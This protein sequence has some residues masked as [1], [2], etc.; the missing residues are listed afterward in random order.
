[1]Q[2]V[3]SIRLLALDFDGVI[4]DS[5]LECAVAA[6]NGYQAFIGNNSRIKAPQEIPTDLLSRFR[7]TRPYIRSGEDYLYLFQAL[8][9]G[10]AIT[11]Q[12]D[13]DS[14]HD[15]HP[16]RRE[17]YYQLFYAEREALMTSDHANWIRLNPP[18]EGMIDFLQSLK[19]EL[20]LRIVS[21]KAVRYIAEILDHHGVRLEPDQIHQAG[22]G[23]SKPDIISRLMQK[24][25][26][27]P[28]EAIFVDDHLDTVEKVSK[29]GVACLLASWGYNTVEQRCSIA[30]SN[31]D[32]IGIIELAGI[33]TDGNN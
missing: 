11:D 24:H 8:A 7:A 30:G 21:T 19:P 26:L 22:R 13:F 18:Y 5:V 29:T 31:I 9:E 27:S 28:C 10:I 16:D 1:M 15:T 2:E 33:M 12:A 20:I 32:L 4:V 23:L 17:P 6:Y 3:R 25:D 14:F